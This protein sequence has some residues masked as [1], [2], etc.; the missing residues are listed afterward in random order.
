[1]LVQKAVVR[2]PGRVIAQAK[3]TGLVGLLQVLRR[4]EDQLPGT[5]RRSLKLWRRAWAESQRRKH[6][7]DLD[8]FI[9]ICNVER[10]LR[11]N[12][13]YMV[14]NTTAPYGNAEAKRVYS[15]DEGPIGP[16]NNLLN[17]GG[18]RLRFL[19][20][21]RY[22]FPTPIRIRYEYT[23]RDG[24]MK[25][26]TGY[27][28]P[29][30]QRSTKVILAHPLLQPL[31][32]VDMIRA[33]VNELCRQCFIHSVPQ[34]AAVNYINLL[35]Y[36][37]RPFLDHIYTQRKTGFGTKIGTNGFVDKV[38]VVLDS[39]LTRVRANHGKKNGRPRRV[40]QKVSDE[41]RSAETTLSLED[42]Q[43]EGISFK[44]LVELKTKVGKEIDGRDFGRLA[45]SIL[46]ESAVIGNRAHKRTSWGRIVPTTE[47]TIVLG[48]DYH[49][50]NR[51]GYQL[52]ANVPVWSGLGKAD[53]VLYVR[54]STSIGVEGEELTPGKWRPVIVVDLKSKAAFDCGIVG[55]RKYGSSG[56]VADEAISKRKLTPQEWH[57]TALNTPSQSESRQLDLYAKGLTAA[58][59]RSTGDDSKNTST[60]VQGILLVDASEFPSRVRNQLENLLISVYERI[61][62][63]LMTH[64]ESKTSAV[65][66]TVEKN[67]LVH[68]R[69]VF[70]V[71]SKSGKMTKMAL[72]LKPFSIPAEGGVAAALP[73]PSELPQL[74]A[75]DLF[76]NRIPDSR[77]FVLYVSAPGTGPGEI[78]SWIARYW[79]GI[80]YAR[81]KVIRNGHESILWLDLAGEF[82]DRVLR[83][84]FLK[85]YAPR[86]AAARTSKRIMKQ[87]RNYRKHMNE[88]LGRVTFLDL[89][90]AIE[91][92][93]LNG[94]DFPCADSLEVRLP[95]YDMFIVSGMDTL[96]NMTPPEAKGLLQTL[97]VNIAEATAVPHST[98]VWFQSAVPT[99]DTSEIYKQHRCRPLPHDSTLQVHVD[100]IILNHQIP[101]APGISESPFMDEIRHVIRF[102]PGNLEKLGPVEI[103]ALRGWSKRF[104]AESVLDAQSSTTYQKG[105][106]G[107]ISRAWTTQGIIAQ[108]VEDDFLDIISAAVV[109]GSRQTNGGQ[110]DNIAHQ[111]RINLDKTELKEKSRTRGYRGVL[112][113]VTLSEDLCNPEMRNVTSRE[114]GVVYHPTK[115]IDTRRKNWTPKLHYEPEETT[116]LPPN[117]S[118]LTL[119][120]VS[121]G[122]ADSIEIKRIMEAIAVLNRA[123]LTEFPMVPDF[124][125]KVMDEFNEIQVRV[126]SRDADLCH[127]LSKTYQNI[128][129]SKT[130]WHSLAYHRA[131]LYAWNPPPGIRAALDAIK[132]KD[133]LRFLRYGNYL[134]MLLSAL[135]EKRGEFALDELYMIW[136]SVK[137]W[138]LLQLGATPN[139]RL[140]PVSKF[141]MQEVFRSLSLRVNSL[142]QIPESSVP[143]FDEIRFGIMADSHNPME[144]PESFYRWYVFEKS[145]FS[146]DFVAGSTIAT[147]Q[148]ERSRTVIP[149]DEQADSAAKCFSNALVI[150]ILIARAYGANILY[151][152]LYDDDS[153]PYFDSE[154]LD[155]RD[156]NWQAKGH[157]RYATRRVGAA[158]SL[159]WIGTSFYTGFPVPTGTSLPRRPLDLSRRMLDHLEEIADVLSV[160]QRVTCTLSGTRDN[161]LAT[162]LF[163][164]GKEAGK[165]GFGET[166]HAV[167]LLRTPYDD[168][169]SVALGRNLL[170]W[171]P[172]LD[173]DYDNSLKSIR[174]LVEK[175]VSS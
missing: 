116:T 5:Y 8:Y 154:D 57:Q 88:F 18:A 139:E 157:L 3:K 145:A 4:G 95:S 24:S 65:R 136:N 49:A 114:K 126:G 144:T 39:V 47:R 62:V 91:Q 131:D 156:I 89:S 55:R 27:G 85:R 63:D 120:T 173:I 167:R 117:E 149:L 147:L 19:A 166:H 108:F 163:Q 1:M 129:Y 21:T 132:Q 92:A 160:A 35:I 52:A 152:P 22:P 112:S 43:P 83:Q 14:F 54:Q 25:A 37:L 76:R 172:L 48:G 86:D 56:I 59:H 100:E 103:P 31:D 67:P 66:G 164:D 134:I 115:K 168:G 70:E 6:L 17:L 94:A 165:I 93:L 174:G 41:G 81:Q 58:Y 50:R 169:V 45:R 105:G 113:R 51:S 162:F 20:M 148:S 42:I 159:K 99:P 61:R 151:T 16:M 44:E 109:R 158:A 11:K 143:S 175:H 90:Y 13:H 137:P 9:P 73:L 71:A 7:G 146:N 124:L 77:H 128:D 46:N 123:S 141:D 118:T 138:I 171:D 15:W 60:I 170:T 33:P 84:A 32:F 10:Y 98:T 68:P 110:T 69:C 102:T 153:F 79:H 97:R 12:H 111:F 64:S 155:Y 23:L 133:K 34:R 150:P 40:S 107:G 96:W 87:E 101:P 142:K 26:A 161:G 122:T 78:A 119:R 28:Y 80:E 130:I 140:K 82:S 74:H 2:R 30:S 36:K 125:R 72:V 106:T 29:G 53:F 121:L 38:D 135:Q 127:E 104:R 75:I